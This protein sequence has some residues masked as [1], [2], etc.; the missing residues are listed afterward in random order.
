MQR[1]KTK[2]ILKFLLKTLHPKFLDNS[3]YNN[4]KNEKAVLLFTNTH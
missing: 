4:E 3:M 1:R 2:Y